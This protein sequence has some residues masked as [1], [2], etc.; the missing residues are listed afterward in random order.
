MRGS[1]SAA[2]HKTGMLER[3]ASCR[4][5][6]LVLGFGHETIRRTWAW[7]R[8]LLPSSDYWLGT[9]RTSTPASASYIWPKKLYLRF[10]Q[11]EGNSFLHSA[12][13]ARSSD[14]RARELGNCPSGIGFFLLHYSYSYSLFPVF[15]KSFSIAI[16]IC[17]FGYVGCHIEKLTKSS[18]L[19][20]LAFHLPWIPLLNYPFLLGHSRVLIGSIPRPVPR[21][22]RFGWQTW[23]RRWFSGR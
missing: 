22:C 5:A 4:H 13:T 8:G 9:L 17:V 23:Q 3:W 16:S 2:S 7:S 1:V 10:L 20:N 12:N 6:N 14:K 18:I 11:L 15:V 21:C 19:I